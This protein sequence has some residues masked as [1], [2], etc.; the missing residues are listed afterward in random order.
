MWKLGL[1]RAIPFL[2]IHKWDFRC[3]A[4]FTLS[5]EYLCDFKNLEVHNDSGIFRARW[6][7]VHEKNLTSKIL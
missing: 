7:V 1:S 5:S 4:W 3:S 6:K 2:G